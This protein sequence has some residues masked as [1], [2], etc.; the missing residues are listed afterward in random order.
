MVENRGVSRVNA[1][2]VAGIATWLFGLLTVFSF[3]IWS[4]FKPLAG[5]TLFDLLDYLTANIM[6]PLGGLLIAL[7]AAW[8]MSRE[9]SMD[10][11]AMGDRFWY[12]LWR[13]LVRYITPVGVAIVFLHAIDI[14]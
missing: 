10:E 9:S 6:L 8:K 4:E 7:F 2:V 5:K 11:L 12:P 1:S 14:I 3:N 13:I